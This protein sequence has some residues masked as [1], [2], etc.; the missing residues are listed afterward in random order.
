[1]SGF[2]SF[3]GQLRLL[4]CG[5]IG[6]SCSS[7]EKANASESPV[8]ASGLR[9]AFFKDPTIMQAKIWS[10]PSFALVGRSPNATHRPGDLYGYR[11]VRSAVAR[12]KR[13]SEV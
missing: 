7:G 13:T 9:V 12:G 1:M 2:A 11:K 10:L 8:E 3:H 5:L 4:R 6:I